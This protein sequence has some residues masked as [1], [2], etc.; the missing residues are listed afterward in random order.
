MSTQR[1]YYEILG[2][3]K[4]ASVEEVKK[5][6]RKLAMSHHPDR[7]PEE[8]KK[9]AEEKFK[10]ISESYAV[11][12]DPKKRQLYDQYGHAG[13]DSRYTQEDIFRG[14]NFSDIFGGGG[15]E[16]I[17]GNI[18]SDFGFDVFGGGRS[19]RGGYRRHS[20]GED[21]QMRAK[22]TLEEA[23]FGTEKE[24]SYY[25]FDSCSACSGSGVKPG[26]SKIT[27]SLCKGSGAV[28]S[29][30]GF[31]S[32]S[33]TCPNCRGQGQVIKDRC[34]ECSGE[35]RVKKQHRLKVKIPKGVKDGSILRLKE[36]GGFLGGGRGDLYLHIAIMPHFKFKR[37]GD[38][39]R[40]YTKIG[41]L[42]AILGTEI[43]VPTLEGKVKM[44]I[45]P[46]TQPDTTFRL[47]NKGLPEINSG[48]VGDELVDIGIEIPK[49]V[50]RKERQ[51]LEE[52]ARLRK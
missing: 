4:G 11:L 41:A 10:E 30:M 39:L 31:I 2:L 9:E 14:A 15:F 51:L 32:V 36:E 12:S 46:G 38:N 26:S 49:K 29:G 42:E 22:I 48:R 25:R 43:E 5:A 50:T 37:E 8:K 3:K 13:V 16:D 23:A 21:L 20:S 52:L 18:F 24:I 28:Q 17:F 33:Q 6:Y 34:R 44:K 27:C 7:V 1:D 45:P 40:Y 35:G 47:K 19:K